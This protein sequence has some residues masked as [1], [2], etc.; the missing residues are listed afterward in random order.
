MAFV[1][2][3]CDMRLAAPSDRVSANTNAT[4]L[5]IAERAAEWVRG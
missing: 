3:M 1:Q 2:L 4:V 5:A